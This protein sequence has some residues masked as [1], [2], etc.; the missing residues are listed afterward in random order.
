MLYYLYFINSN[1]YI[2]KFLEKY[3]LYQSEFIILKLLN[4]S[5]DIILKAYPS[6]SDFILHTSAF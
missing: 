4:I 6:K 3:L 5:F 2:L 1:L